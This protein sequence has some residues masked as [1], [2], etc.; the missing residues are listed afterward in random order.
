MQQQ[1]QHWVDSLVTEIQS[2]QE[3][4]RTS[5]LHVDDMK[6]P[7]GRVHVGALRGVILHDVVA[8]VL[9]NKIGQPI[10]S[11]YVFNNMDNMDSLPKYL[12]EEYASHM[13]RSLHKIPPPPL[14]HCGID[15]SA[16]TPAETA[17]YQTASN[18]GELYA[19]DFIDAFRKLGCSQEIIW[20]N[21]L[22][23]SGAMD[24][25]IRTALDSVAVLKKIYKETADYELPDKW[26]PFQVICESCGLVGSTLTTD[27]DGT[28]VAYTCLEKKVEWAK[29]CG[30]SGRVSPFG[31]TGKLL[32]K[33]DWPGHWKSLG[34]TIEG[35][36]KDHTSAG[37]SRD[38]ANAI[39]EQVLKI[40]TPFDI[41][42]EWILVRGAK[43]S[44]SKGV[45][46]AAREFVDSLPA[47]LGRFLF[48]DKHYNQVIDFD[49]ST[50]AIPDLFDEYDLAARIFWK[51]VAGDARLGRS[52][53]LCQINQVPPQAH[54]LPRF[55]DVA[56]WMQHPELNLIEYFTK[57]KGA[58]LNDLELQE[59]AEREKYAWMWVNKH[60]PSEFQLTPRPEVPDVA[61]SLTSEQRAF[62][63]QLNE[64]MDSKN[65]WRAEDLQQALFELAKSTLGTKAGFQAIY[66]A[67][68][69]KTAG[70]KAGWFLLAI[71]QKLRSERIAVLT[72]QTS[73]VESKHLFANLNRPDILTISDSVRKNYP[74]LIIGTAIIEGVSVENSSDELL[75][76]LKATYDAV[77]DIS[78]DEINGSHKIQSYRQAIRQSGIDWHSRR[79]T[80]DALLRRI[81]KGMPPKSINN[82]ADI[83]NMLAVK[84]HMSQGLFD[85][86][87]L[88]FPT[89]FKEASGGEEAVLFGDDASTVLKAGEVCYFDQAG[90]FAVD[91][92]WRDAQRTSVTEKTST[93][94]I[95][96]EGVLTISRNDVEKMLADLIAYI[97]KYAGGTVECS[98]IISVEGK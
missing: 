87:R 60:A 27:W 97:L 17:R 13:G 67:F 6:T 39:C 74:S 70:P 65:D 56:V 33:V 37:G 9:S 8:K 77:K 18:M 96:T 1:S 38:M 90:P 3:K 66:L 54:F 21:E 40:V 94:L 35:A 78:V 43:M 46:T 42:Y 92:C 44:S 31:G 34:I 95:Q 57:E 80:M 23:E 15:F 98:G 88:Q 55:R 51:E 52:F 50:L 10:T 2:W 24:V 28:T 83:G 32:W 79:P 48:V 5:K 41:P 63:Q 19:F 71:D 12:P 75:A 69:G 7:S 20:S 29:G 85:Y 73:E 86:D 89:E 25:V 36:G 58:P 76:E 26:Y 82:V 4:N 16:A 81:Q 64:L 84:H 11:T 62:L 91:L 49:P 93:L 61:S 47:T 30:H 59:L 22:Y 14:E 72:I 53:E 68:L 45:G